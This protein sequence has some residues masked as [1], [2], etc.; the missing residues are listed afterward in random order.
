[1][2]LQLLND[3]PKM[4]HPYDRASDKLFSVSIYP[5]LFWAWYGCNVLVDKLEVQPHNTKRRGFWLHIKSY[6]FICQS[7]WTLIERIFYFLFL[8]KR[9]Y[10][11]G[12]VCY[13]RLFYVAFTHVSELEGFCVQDAVCDCV[14]TKHWN[15]LMWFFKSSLQ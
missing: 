2:F 11:G 14:S 12:L 15:P 1:M 9:M 5:Y 7:I 6:A 13:W 10:C 4:L 8:E 3:V